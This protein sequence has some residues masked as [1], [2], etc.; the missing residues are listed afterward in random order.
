MK[1]TLKIL[2]LCGVLLAGMYLFTDSHLRMDVKIENGQDRFYISDY[3][4]V[5][6][7]SGRDLTNLDLRL[8]IKR[9]CANGDYECNKDGGVWPIWK[10]GETRQL[11]TFIIEDD[12]VTS[13]KLQGTCDQG[14]ID[15]ERQL[16][17]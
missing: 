5:T 1:T 7:R 2:V 12:P 14:K 16:K 8:T 11:S 10:K 4:Y 13:L 3:Y 17:Q 6:N 9:E 15:L